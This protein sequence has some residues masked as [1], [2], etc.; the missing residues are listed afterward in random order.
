MQSIRRAAISFRCS[1]VIDLS[2]RGATAVLEV[3]SDLESGSPVVLP[4]DPIS[5]PST[6]LELQRR[7]VIRGTSNEDV[8]WLNEQDVIEDHVLQLL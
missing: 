3:A 5:R 4:G 6:D 2:H 8:L 7:L 1:V